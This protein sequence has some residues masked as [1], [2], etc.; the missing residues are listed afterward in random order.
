MEKLTD[1]VWNISAK[2]TNHV[3]EHQ[4]LLHRFSE[5]EEPDCDPEWEEFVDKD[6]KLIEEV[7]AELAELVRQVV[8]QEKRRLMA[9]LRGS[10]N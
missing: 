7:A 1:A 5:L 9:A 3:V 4:K 6:G 2:L 8:E 10:L